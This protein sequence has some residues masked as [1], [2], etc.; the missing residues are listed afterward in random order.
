MICACTCAGAMVAIAFVHNLVRR[1]PSLMVL[2]HNPRAAAGGALLLDGDGEAAQQ[3]GRAGCPDPYDDQ[4]P[5]P[6]K[7]RAVDSSLWEL[8]CLRNHYCPQVGCTCVC[9][10][11]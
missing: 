7:S 2:L 3:E 9:V 11:V 10:C 1:H 4:Q 8:A 5:D 6:A